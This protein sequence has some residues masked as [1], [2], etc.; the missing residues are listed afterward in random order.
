[1][2]QTFMLDRDTNN[3]GRADGVYASLHRDMLV[4]V[5]VPDPPPEGTD[6]H[7]PVIFYSHGAT[8]DITS[9][10]ADRNPQNL[11]N[12]G[13][14]VIAP[15][16]QDIGAILTTSQFHR[17]RPDSTT[18]RVEDFND[19]G[20]AAI[21]DAIM[22]QFNA[23]NG[24]AIVW[25]ADLTTPVIAGHS[26]GAFTA[27]LLI[28]VDSAR[29]EFANLEAN[30][31]FEAAILFSPQG[32]PTAAQEDPSL[33]LDPLFTPF[34]ATRSQIAAFYRRDLDDN[35][36]DGDYWTGLYATTNASGQVIASSWD[37]VTV[38]VLSITG[39]VDAG[40]AG[41]NYQH[42]RDGF[43]YGDQDGR[44]LV[45]VRGAGH[46]ELGGFYASTD[47]GVHETIASV[48]GD[49]LD[50]YVHGNATALAALN[51]VQGYAAAYPLLAEVFEA[52]GAPTGYLV[53]T[54]GADALEGAQTSD[55][56]V[57]G[58]GNDTMNGYNANDVL[59]GGAG[60][61]IMTGGNGDDVFVFSSV[62]DS[63]TGSSTRDQIADFDDFGNDILDLSAFDNLVYVGTDAFN[64][65]N[66]VRV[67]QSGSHVLI[68][69]NTDADSSAESVIQLT[70]TTL[71]QID[72]S[73]FIFG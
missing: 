50:A 49:F 73:D 18:E 66:Q 46:S 64:A 51:D 22:A 24:G 60:R 3:D 34:G 25:S 62:S 8:V 31:F 61:D 16:H 45:V 63:G 6:G 70:N 13:Y 42:R 17:N 39:T 32:V 47:G 65:A 37:N 9:T 44:H 4:S 67:I 20:D 23:Q 59:I 69:I 1:M 28:G 56:I 72:S 29:P 33:L 36:N 12:Q 54:T 21:V 14:I 55:L 30:P 7:L 71:S 43:E 57:G 15:Q 53:G 11:A 27:Q 26:Q 5:F 41:Q 35:G 68:Q 19:L 2:S 58:A 38:P 52:S 48:A 10:G 40:D